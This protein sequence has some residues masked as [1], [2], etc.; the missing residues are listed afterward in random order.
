[1]LTNLK[2]IALIALVLAL[3]QCQKP[4]IWGGNFQY[5]VNVSILY[6]DPIMRWNFTYYY[7]WN[8]KA[9]RYEHRAP[10]VDEM[11]LLAE[12]P[13][14]VNDSCVV[15]FA[16]DG[17]SY[18]EYPAHN[19]CCKCENQL[20]AIRSDWLQLNS[21]YVG[22]EIMNG[23]SVTHWTKMGQYLNHYYSTVDRAL[24]IKY[25]ELKK[26]N[27]KQ[28]DFDLKSYQAGPFDP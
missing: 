17:W 12:P 3:T 23:T 1:M 4:P 25:Y 21:T 5:V 2:F 26:G 11:C 14:G 13:F 7:N 19:W 9:E 20:G 22:T 27:P 16:T 24:P 8:F 18:I 28:W 6:D 10:Q 15:T